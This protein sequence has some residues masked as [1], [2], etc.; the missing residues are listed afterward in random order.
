[1]YLD[2]LKQP[3]FVGSWTKR[4]EGVFHSA[5]CTTTSQT[6]PLAVVFGHL[7]G[8][9]LDEK[10]RNSLACS[11]SSLIARLKFDSFYNEPARFISSQ[12]E[13]QLNWL[14]PYGHTSLGSSAQLNCETLTLYTTQPSS[15]LHLFCFI[16]EFYMDEWVICKLYEYWFRWA[17]WKRILWKCGSINGL[18]SP[19]LKL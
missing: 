15:R 17:G 18:Y 16:L 13:Q 11:T 4:M 12:L 1:M 2:L 9:R 10:T 6:V 8:S 7:L 3:T 5:C 14:G 19:L